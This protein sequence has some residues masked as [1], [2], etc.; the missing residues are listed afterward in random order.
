MKKEKK[1]GKNKI[2]MR[3]KKLQVKNKT[4]GPW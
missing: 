2:K 3:I 4:S 1:R